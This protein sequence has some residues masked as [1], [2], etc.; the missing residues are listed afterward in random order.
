MY[1]V[2]RPKYLLIALTSALLVASHA[3]ADTPPS[4]TDLYRWTLNSIDKSALKDPTAAKESLELQSA[5]VAAFRTNSGLTLD[6]AKNGAEAAVSE[7]CKRQRV[8]AD[9]LNRCVSG[10]KPVM[11]AFLDK[12]FSRASVADASA[13]LTSQKSL[14]TWVS[15]DSKLSGRDKTQI[16]A[17]AS[18]N[19]GA[20][21]A[22]AP[23][24]PAPPKPVLPNGS[25]GTPPGSA[26]PAAENAAGSTPPVTEAPNTPSSETA[27]LVLP[28][29]PDNVRLQDPVVRYNESEQHERDGNEI[30]YPM[31]KY[32]HAAQNSIM[33]S[34]GST[35]ACPLR[36]Q[37]EDQLFS[38][39]FLKDHPCADP[40]AQYN[41]N[42]LAEIPR[43]HHDLAAIQAKRRAD[44]ETAVAALKGSPSAK[45]ALRKKLTE[46]SI[47]LKA[48][49]GYRYSTRTGVQPGDGVN[50]PIEGGGAVVFG[51]SDNNASY[52]SGALYT[53]FTRTIAHIDDGAIF[54]QM[55]GPDGKPDAAQLASFSPRKDEKNKRLKDDDDGVFGII[56]NNYA[57][58]AD[59]NSAM[60][61]NAFGK[62]IGKRKD[63]A[64]LAQACAG[65]MVK[66]DRPPS[67]AFPLG[68]G[69]AGVFLG[70]EAGMVYYWSANGGTLGYGVT[71]E[72]EKDMMPMIVRLTKPYNVA[73]IPPN[74]SIQRNVYRWE[75][76]GKN[77]HRVLVIPE[78]LTFDIPQKYQERALA[79]Q[80]ALARARVA[81]AGQSTSAE[82]TPALVP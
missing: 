29:V 8:I 7:W 49:G 2:R 69:H 37:F 40:E 66:W 10:Y 41:Q 27:P 62:E 30:K 23:A 51:G 76:K 4:V 14:K 15:P 1:T 81:A 77:R 80:T 72:P 28:S 35:K 34:M 9:D 52:C 57:S 48:R 78:R 70:R 6:S 67:K 50:V 55:R 11:E 64:A 43:I 53:I 82:T 74:A 58:I 68:S 61:K 12:V 33:D 16:R 22:P 31:L 63:R 19:P 42:V 56:N 32:T 36:K 65:D 54:R 18:L 38:G 59:L 5:L 44:I 24:P 75:G 21:A 3:A 39:T 13:I 73:A 45:A 46:D 60:G 17:L 20:A 47:I 26:K 79:A 25:T 71:C